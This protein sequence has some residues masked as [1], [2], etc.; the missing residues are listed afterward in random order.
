MVTYRWK[1][2]QYSRK[3]RIKIKIPTIVPLQNVTIVY[4]LQL[5]TLIKKL[6][7]KNLINGQYSF[8][9]KVN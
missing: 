8:L 2:T 9:Q 4:Q 5:L 3:T 1:T 7:R 6:Q